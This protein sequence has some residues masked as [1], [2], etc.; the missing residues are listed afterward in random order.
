LTSILQEVIR[1][2]ALQCHD[3]SDLQHSFA[4]LLQEQL[5]TL[6]TSYTNVQVDY[7][8]HK[9][10]LRAQNL[11]NEAFQNLRMD[12]RRHAE[13]LRNTANLQNIVPSTGPGFR[14]PEC[15]VCYET[16]ET[17]APTTTHDDGSCMNTFCKECFDAWAAHAPAGRLSCLTC[18]VKLSYVWSQ[19]ED[20]GYWVTPHDDD[21]D[22]E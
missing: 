3:I 1:E 6:P 13:E 19:L 12:L 14:D 18:R 22:S 10:M 4:I 21:Y 17:D 16:V 11:T 8:R 7:I 9:V 15:K 5:K 20:D 2:P